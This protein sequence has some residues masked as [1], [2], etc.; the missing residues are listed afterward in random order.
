MELLGE[1]W[2][3]MGIDEV[4]HATRQKMG[5]NQKGQRRATSSPINASPTSLVLSHVTVD[6]ISTVVRKIESRRTKKPT[7]GNEYHHN[8]IKLNIIIM[9]G[10]NRITQEEI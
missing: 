10:T 6:H 3:A 5:N 2:V 9:K 4:E 1:E 7:Q 8:I